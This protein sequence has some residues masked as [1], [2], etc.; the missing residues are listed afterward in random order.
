VLQ[1][2][3]TQPLG[4]HEHKLQISADSRSSPPRLPIG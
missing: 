4:E 3:V 2:P 1:L